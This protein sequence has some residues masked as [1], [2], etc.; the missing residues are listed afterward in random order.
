MK[1]VTPEQM[2][3]LVTYVTGHHNNMLENRSVCCG[4]AYFEWSN[5]LWKAD[6]PGFQCNQPNAAPACHTQVWDPGPDMGAQPQFPGGFWDEEA[7]GLFA[8]APVDPQKRVPVTPGG[9]VGPWNPQANA[10]YP[11]DTL[12]M[13]DHAKALFKAF[14]DRLYVVNY[15]SNVAITKYVGP[16]DRSKNPALKITVGPKSF[17]AVNTHQV[18]GGP[19]WQVTESPSG[20]YLSATDVTSL[21]AVIAFQSG[22]LTAIAY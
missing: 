17:T 19:P 21:P 4:G 1:S 7:F 15:G 5:E 20:P 2:A 13:L 12:T 3:N 10:P 8:I 18:T 6:P 11:P 22:Q 9:C 16:K 14:D